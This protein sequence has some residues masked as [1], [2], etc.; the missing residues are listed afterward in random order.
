[1]EQR[2]NQLHFFTQSLLSIETIKEYLTNQIKG[3]VKKI[4]EDIMIED[5][6]NTEFVYKGLEEIANKLTGFKSKI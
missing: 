3:K 5:T 6:I 4:N 2:E 1:M